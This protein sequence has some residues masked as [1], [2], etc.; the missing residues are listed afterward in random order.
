MRYINSR[1]KAGFRRNREH[2]IVLKG[3]GAE[4]GV[5]DSTVKKVETG[6]KPE[7]ERDQMRESIRDEE[8]WK[9]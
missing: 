3:K 5:V 8:M 6:N 1:H 2:Q 4:D 7:E 9:F